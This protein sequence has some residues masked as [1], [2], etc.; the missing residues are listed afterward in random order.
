MSNELVYAMSV[1]GKMTVDQFYELLNSI[2]V[3]EDT[4]VEGAGYDIRNTVIRVLESLGYCEFDFRSR[5]VFMCPTCMIRLP[6]LGTPKAVITGAQT[7]YLVEFV[8]KKI[9]GKSER[10]LIL[11]VPQRSSIINLPPLLCIEAD[12]ISTLEEISNDCNIAY[13]LD[14][15]TSWLLVKMSESEQDIRN[16]LDFIKRSWDPK[17]MKIYDAERLAF[18]SSDMECDEC[19][20]QYKSQIDHQ[21][22]FLYWKDNKSAEIGKDWGRYAI[23]SRMKRKI[24]IYDKMLRLLAVPKAVPL[25]TILARALVFCTGTPPFKGQ[26]TFENS[27]D[28]PLGYYL[29]IYSGVSKELA[30][31][32][33]IKLGQE[34]QY[35]SLINKR[36]N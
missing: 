1:K 25:P 34:L 32:I 5:Q 30:N 26:I 35:Y 27:T 8:K 17:T 28:I 16:K 12:A 24:L 3:R 31:E 4:D 22:Y 2:E 9:K 36:D 21:F 19:L 20:V 14:I 18:I 13:R 23:L 15:P 7:P 33:A 11:N 29:D 6:S 10:A